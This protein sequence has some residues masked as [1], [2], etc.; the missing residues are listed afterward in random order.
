[1]HVELNSLADDRRISRITLLPE[2]V[3]Q[4]CCATA[5]APVVGSG[6]SPSNRRPDTECAKEVA[7]HKQSIDEL[8]LSARRH[9]EPRRGPG[10]GAGKDVLTVAQSFPDRIRYGDSADFHLQQ[11]FRMLDGQIF[12]H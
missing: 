3:A 8:A 5:A 12:Q 9:I 10:K 1:M 4:D 7:T 11:F 2:A 6:E